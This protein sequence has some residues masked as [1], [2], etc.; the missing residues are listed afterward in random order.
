MGHDVHTASDGEK[1]VVAAA[2][3]MPEVVLLD[4]QMP[5]VN[6]YE[7]CRHIRAIPGGESI[8]IVA[9]TG[10]GQDRD[11][12]DSASAGFDHHLVKPVDPAELGALIRRLGPERGRVSGS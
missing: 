8:L 5:N 10:R 3:L 11:R 12:A 9:V 4:I 2:R 6:G 7:A 1:A